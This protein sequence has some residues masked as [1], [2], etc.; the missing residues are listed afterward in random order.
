MR[1]SPVRRGDGLPMCDACGLFHSRVWLAVMGYLDLAPIHAFFFCDED[2]VKLADQ[3][4]LVE[5]GLSGERIG[6][7]VHGCRLAVDDIIF[8]ETEIV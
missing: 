4:A 6:V 5:L 2:M 8:W 1:S 7:T 3:Q